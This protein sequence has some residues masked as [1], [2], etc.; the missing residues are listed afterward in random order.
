MVSK[1]FPTLLNTTF[2][3]GWLH[4]KLWVSFTVCLFSTT[5]VVTLV[6]QTPHVENW[7][8][9]EVHHWGFE[10]SL[11]ST[12][13][14]SLLCTVEESECLV[15]PRVLTQG[16][17]VL[18]WYKLRSNTFFRLH[19][20]TLSERCKSGFSFWSPRPD[21]GKLFFQ[22]LPSET[23]AVLSRFDLVRMERRR[24]T[25]TRLIRVWRLID[26]IVDFMINSII[27]EE[28]KDC[29]LSNFNQ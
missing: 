25:P 9:R 27:I 26:L 22:D 16:T 20:V 23:R 15:P 29:I 19:L 4:I 13:G 8:P 18:W 10:K 6:L 7:P 21:A 3:L 24:D 14:G 1:K 17:I 5:G 12:V 11:V 28:N 2:I